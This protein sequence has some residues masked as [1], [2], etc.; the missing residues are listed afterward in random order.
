MRLT[1][2]ESVVVL[3]ED[4]FSEAKREAGAK[5]ELPPQL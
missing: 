1:L 4:V 2:T 3:R 5:P